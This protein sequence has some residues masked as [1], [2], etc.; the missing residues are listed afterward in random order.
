VSFFSV[1]SD[2]GDIEDLMGRLSARLSELESTGE[3]GRHQTALLPTSG[4]SISLDDQIRALHALWMINPNEIIRS[5]R[6]RFGEAIRRFQRFVRRMTFWYTVPLID[7]VTAFNGGVV[8]AIAGLREQ[9]L[10]LRNEIDYL[11][12]MT[13][14]R[15]ADRESMPADSDSADIRQA[16]AAING[17]LTAIESRL[18]ALNGDPS[19]E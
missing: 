7:Q 1:K 9:Q 2:R 12:A 3:L 15:L 18:Q 8:R 10:A 13:A 5:N 4:Q 17:R 14:S 16:L 11:T 6:P 19:D